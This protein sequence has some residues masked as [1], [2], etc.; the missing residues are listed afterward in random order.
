MNTAF[1]PNCTKY[2]PKNKNYIKKEKE[3]GTKRKEREVP[4]HTLSNNNNKYK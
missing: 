4:T 3:R 2:L 1:E